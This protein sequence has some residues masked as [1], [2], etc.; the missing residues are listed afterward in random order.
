MS[1]MRISIILC[2]F[3]RFIPSPGGGSEPSTP[4]LRSPPPPPPHKSAEK[5]TNQAVLLTIWGRQAAR[6][7]E[8]TMEGVSVHRL[9]QRVRVLPLE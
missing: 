1:Q 9:T 2:V 3:H 4:T 5:I 8:T 6:L 7:N